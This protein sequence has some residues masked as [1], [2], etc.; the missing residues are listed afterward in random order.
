MSALAIDTIARTIFGEARGE[1][2]NGMV[3]VANVI[4]NRSRKPGWWGRD[5]VSCATAPYQ[6][7]CWNMNDPNRPKLLAVTGEADPWFYVAE[8]I[9]GLALTNRLTDITHGADSYYAEGTTPPRWA[10]TAPLTT[11]IGRHRF[12]R[13]AA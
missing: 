5:P 6:F 12:Y 13:V 7:S 1:D 2:F 8:G 4:I 10:L 9:A 3:A 11:V